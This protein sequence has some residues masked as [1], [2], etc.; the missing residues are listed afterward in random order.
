MS[1]I[2]DIVSRHVVDS[3]SFPLWL[4]DSPELAVLAKNGA[5]APMMLYSPEDIKTVVDY[6]GVRG[7]DVVMVITRTLLER[8]DSIDDEQEIDTPGH[9]DAIALSYPELVAC[10]EKTPWSA[11]VS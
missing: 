9:T 8:N 1:L 4:R 11:N 10:H 5:Y 3:Q 6:A 7:I 2:L